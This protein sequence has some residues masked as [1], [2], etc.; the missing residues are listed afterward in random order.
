MT[1][2]ALANVPAHVAF[3]ISKGELLPYQG[4]TNEM[5]AK[6]MYEQLGSEDEK[7]RLQIYWYTGKDQIK[8]VNAKDKSRNCHVKLMGRCGY[9]ESM[10]ER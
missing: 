3:L 7:A 5:V 9:P 1:F 2:A 8:P 6:S 10:Q 4:G